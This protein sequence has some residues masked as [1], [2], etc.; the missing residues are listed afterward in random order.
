MDKH[1]LLDNVLPPRFGLFTPPEILTDAIIPAPPPFLIPCIAPQL[2][3]PGAFKLWAQT[4]SP[5]PWKDLIYIKLSPASQKPKYLTGLLPS[6][7]LYSTQDLLINNSR[8]SNY[9]QSPTLENK[10]VYLHFATPPPPNSCKA[11]TKPRLT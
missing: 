4:P 10:L 5:L 9:G 2:T 1:P 8:G 11:S 3:Q 6:S 7:P